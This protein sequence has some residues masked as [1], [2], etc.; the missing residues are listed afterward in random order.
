MQDFIN[1]LGEVVLIVTFQHRE[2]RMRR[3]YSPWKE[4]IAAPRKRI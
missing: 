1:I 3:D 4:R 2:A